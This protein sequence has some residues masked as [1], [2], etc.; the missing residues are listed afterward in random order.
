MPRPLPKLPIL[1]RAGSGFHTI[2][3]AGTLF[4]QPG[5]S[6]LD[7]GSPDLG[8]V[9]V[10][11][12]AGQRLLKKLVFPLGTSPAG[13]VADVDSGAMSLR[14]N[15]P[16]Y[17][18][19]ISYGKHTVNWLGGGSLPL[20]FDGGNSPATGIMP[21]LQILAE[22]PLPGKAAGIPTAAPWWIRW[23]GA[24]ASGHMASTTILF[25]FLSS[26]IQL[27]PPP[28]NSTVNSFFPAVASQ[29]G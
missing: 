16:F 7:P 10:L 4:V 21:T 3:A 22:P 19:A 11:F 15:E 5:P 27:P 8:Q 14:A 6:G 18:T 12:H 26:Q 25:S 28:N 24:F 13:I 29:S 2:R 17:A 9:V 1:L 23:P 20:F